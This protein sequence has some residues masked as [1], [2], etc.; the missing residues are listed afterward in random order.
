MNIISLFSP[1]LSD[2]HVRHHS[3]L[4]LCVDR[5]WCKNIAWL[6]EANVSD[7]LTTLLLQIVHRTLAAMIGSTC[8]LA[9]LSMLDKVCRCGIQC[10]L[11]CSNASTMLSASITW[12]SG[13]VDGL[14]HNLPPLWNGQSLLDAPQF[15]VDITSLPPSLLTSSFPPSLSLS[16]SLL[17]LP[18]SRSQMV[19]VG[20][21]SQTGFFDYSA[22]KAYKLARGRPGLLIALLCLF[23]AVVSAF[24]VRFTGYQI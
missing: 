5:L 17:T 15:S 7:Y 12:D 24:L 16:P 13:G 1:H 2:N 21:F 9:V 3:C 18:P 6:L 23:S 14:G 11:A 8:T 4:G 19:L 10:S 20:I 22:V